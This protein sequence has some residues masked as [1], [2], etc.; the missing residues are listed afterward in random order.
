MYHIHTHAR[1]ATPDSGNT[2]TATQSVNIV[3]TSHPDSCYS[4][5]LISDQTPHL[6]YVVRPNPIRNLQIDQF[7]R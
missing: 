2:P 3:I 7:E 6:P 1:W 4:P 5:T